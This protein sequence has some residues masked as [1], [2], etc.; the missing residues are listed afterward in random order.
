MF[1]SFE[2]ACTER[3]VDTN[4][5]FSVYTDE[6]PYVFLL[7]TNAKRFGAFNVPVF[8]YL[9]AFIYF[10]SISPSKAHTKTGLQLLATFFKCIQET[11][12]ERWYSVKQSVMQMN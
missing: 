2:R 3:T 1:V 6:R 10:C 5:D 9:H 4:L 12:G 8:C 11:M 7:V